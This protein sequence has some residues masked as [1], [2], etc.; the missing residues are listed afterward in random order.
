[1]NHKRK[2]NLLVLLII[3][4]TVLGLGFVMSAMADES[5]APSH[6]KSLTVNNDGTYE[7]ALDVT[8][9]ADTT[10]TTAKANILI[11]YDRSGSMA[12]RVESSTGDYTAYRNG[13]KLYKYS[14]YRCSQ[15]SPTEGWT[16]TVY[17]S[18]YC[19]NDSV[20]T[21]KRYSSAVTRGAAAEKTVYDF[22]TNLYRYNTTAEPNNVQMALV[23][24]SSNAATAQTWTNNKNTYLNH[25][26][27]SG[28]TTEQNYSG[29][30]NWEASL[31]QALTVLRSAD[32]D[33]TF[34]VFVTDGGPTYRVGGG[35]GSSITEEN[36]RA[37]ID[38]ALDIQNYDTATHT[39][40]AQTRN[41][42]MY[43]I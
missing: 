28:T 19:T 11:I 43:G 36:Y 18:N 24:F 5:T 27:S 42:Q 41:T 21:G 25:F 14:N 37:A 4:V 38:E 6:N 22:A 1:M 8:G 20:Y 13:S 3:T 12:W 32:S 7:I 16:G 2:S 39:S 15:V 33:P 10:S 40:N 35:N 29:G 34:V 31:D 26:A 30:T 17:T 9:S 23:T